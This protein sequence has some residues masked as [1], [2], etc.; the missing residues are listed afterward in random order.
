MQT[1][2]SNLLIQ[3][4]IL[5]IKKKVLKDRLRQ[6]TPEGLSW[7]LVKQ[8]Y[9]KT[10]IRVIWKNI[11]Y[12]KCTSKMTTFRLYFSDKNET[13]IRA[14]GE[15]VGYTLMKNSENGER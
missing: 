2:I 1:K 3:R 9:L 12:G 14:I 6:L 5:F 11:E 7:H 4:N 10:L 8:R 13:E 15:V